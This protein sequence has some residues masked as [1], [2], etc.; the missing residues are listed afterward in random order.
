MNKIKKYESII[1]EL[2]NEYATI[3]PANMAEYEN[4]IIAD[5]ERHHYRSCQVFLIPFKSTTYAQ[6]A[7]LPV[8]AGQAVKF[9]KTDT[10]YSRRLCRA[11]AVVRFHSF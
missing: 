4:Q 5:A 1:L 10:Y 3:Q 8:K 6:N 2:L 9:F 11:L 7:R